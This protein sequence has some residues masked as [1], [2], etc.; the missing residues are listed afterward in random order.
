M[1]ISHADDLPGYRPLYQ[2]L[3][4][5]FVESIHYGAA[6]V[7]T[8]DGQLYA[9]TGDPQSRTF[10]RSS[11]KPIQA[12]PLLE[13]GGVE[14]F[15]LSLEELSV[16]CASHSG[17]DQHLRT[18]V[19]LQRKIGIKESDLLCGSHLP[20]DPA[21][22]RKLR[23]RGLKPTQNHHNCSGK[24]TGMLAQARLLEV[25][26]EGYTEPEHPVQGGILAVVAEMCGLDQGE[27]VLGRDGC[28]VPSYAIPLFN[29]A[30]AWAKM[31][32]PRALPARPGDA[33]RQI[34][35]AMTSQPFYVA[36]PGRLDTRLMEGAP[37]RIV[38]KAGA[39]AFQAIGVLP[40]AIGPGSPALGIALKIADGDQG[41]RALSAVTLEILR[42][43]GVLSEEDLQKFDDLGPI[44]TLRNR[45]GIVTGQAEPCFQLQYE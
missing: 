10:M 1:M 2:C 3:R 42:Q 40:H 26:L 25:P 28:S 45:A 15:Q 14:K 32:D 7:V 8:A 19:R 18:I 17:T 11:A 23:D 20:Y 9:W 6:A 22:Q 41:K 16:I 21:S 38:S 39:E 27:I 36:G 37:G 29:A 5:G 33:L 12:I 13:M 43:L 44:Q 4:N 35:L 34:V 30:W 24:H 31:A